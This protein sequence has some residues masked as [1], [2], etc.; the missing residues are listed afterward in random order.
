[1]DMFRKV[2]V[3]KKIIGWCSAGPSVP[4]TDIRIPTEAYISVEEPRQDRDVDRSFEHFP[5]ATN[6]A[7]AEEVRVGH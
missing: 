4:P 5:R 3:R 7:D 6:A 2:S 1:M